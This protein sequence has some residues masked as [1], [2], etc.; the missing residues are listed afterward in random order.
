MD[1][2]AVTTGVVTT[3]VLYGGSLGIYHR[4][5]PRSAGSQSGRSATFI[6]RYRNVAWALAACFLIVAVVGV[7]TSSTAVFLVGFCG[8]SANLVGA[9]E[10]REE[11]V[12]KRNAV[13]GSPVRGAASMRFYLAA[14]AS[15]MLACAAAL[16]MANGEGLLSV[17][18]ALGA[19]ALALYAG[20]TSRRRTTS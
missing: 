8:G 14:A 5:F 16:S 3:L 17:P 4:R 1:A 11:L 6:R 19:A 20:L 13:A 2:V 12:R 15:V 9:V 7:V 18:L 10:A